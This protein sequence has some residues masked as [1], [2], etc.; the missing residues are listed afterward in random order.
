MHILFAILAVISLFYVIIQSVI[1]LDSSMAKKKKKKKVKKVNNLVAKYAK[2]F[3]L[4]HVF[5]DR[6]KYSRK[7]DKK[8]ISEE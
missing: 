2:K 3:T 4:A 7:D 5:R 6:K 1:D 8:K